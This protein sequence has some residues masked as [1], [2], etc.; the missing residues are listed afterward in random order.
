MQATAQQND[1]AGGGDDSNSGS[2]SN[3]YYGI[4]GGGSIG[5]GTA[6]LDMA[7][8]LSILSASLLSAVRECEKK[9]GL[10]K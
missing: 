4:A 2:S 9:G 8:G 1:Q 3:S 7:H 6:R 10:K 5:K